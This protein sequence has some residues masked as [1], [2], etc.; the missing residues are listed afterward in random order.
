LRSLRLLLGMTTAT[1]CGSAFV[2][3]GMVGDASG[4][5]AVLLAAAVPVA[6][7]SWAL[8]VSLGDRHH[9]DHS[10]PADPPGPVER[11]HSLR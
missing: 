6:G 7:L 2:I 3:G 10:Q 9:D 4:W 5:S 1:V 11:E 8:V